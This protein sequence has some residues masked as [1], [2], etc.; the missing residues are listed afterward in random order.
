MI[1]QAPL[2]QVIGT[3]QA[4]FDKINVAVATELGVCVVANTGVAPEPVAEFTVGL[5][6]ALARRIVKADRDLRRMKDWKARGPYGDPQKDMGI[7]LKGATIGVAGFG[8]IGA[9][10]ARFCQALFSARVLAYDPFV[11]KEQMAA[12]GVEKVENIADLAKQ[13]QFL[14]LHVALTKDTRQF[15][16]EAVLR[17]MRKDAYIVNC[18]RGQ[19][20][21]QQV[22]IQAIKEGWIRG[23][24]LDVFEDEPIAADN[25]LLTMDNVIVTPHIGGVTLGSSVTKGQEIVRKVLDALAGTRPDGLVNPDAWATFEK[26]FSKKGA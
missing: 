23:A 10:V 24:A 5:M 2:L 17:G 8:N 11:S 6:L 22:L 25:P 21:D 1:R 4:G 3:P 19:V 14:L 26:R 20:I 15:I 9:T 16:S 18:A 12:L 13:V 7:D